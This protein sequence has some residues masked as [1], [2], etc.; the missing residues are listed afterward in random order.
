MLSSFRGQYFFVS[1]DVISALEFAL[2][3]L[4]LSFCMSLAFW[5]RALIVFDGSLFSIVESFSNVILGTSMCRSILS[6]SGPEILP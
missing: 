2:F 6:R 4:N 5:T 1:W 3:C